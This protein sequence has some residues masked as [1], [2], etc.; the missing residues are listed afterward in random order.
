[1]HFWHFYYLLC[2]RAPLAYTVIQCQ[3]QV[4]GIDK[5]KNGITMQT[6][7]SASHCV[8]ERL[9]P[10]H[11]KFVSCICVQKAGMLEQHRFCLADHCIA[12][13]PVKWI[14]CGRLGS[15][16]VEIFIIFDVKFNWRLV[17]RERRF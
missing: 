8:F 14:V 6:H 11:F 13:V 5:K 7:L 2:S 9:F 1:M 4:W 10:R 3:C 12:N 17:Q 16:D 15:V